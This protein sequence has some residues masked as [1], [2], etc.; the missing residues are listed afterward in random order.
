M[1]TC[2][3]GFKPNSDQIEEIKVCLIDEEKNYKEDFFCNWASVQQSFSDNKIAVLIQNKNAIGFISW[4]E[5]EKVARIQIAE[6]RPGYRKKGFGKYLAEKLFENL[7][8]RG[9][10][11]LDLHC[12]PASSEKVWKKLGFKRF[13]GARDFERE[14]S[15]NGRYLYKVLVPH[16]RPAK[17]LTA[18]ESIEI[19]YAEPH[20]ARTEPAQLRWHPKFEKGTRN[21]VKPIIAS[22]KRDWQISWNK[23]E[24][25]LK[26]DKIKYFS[27]NKID[28]GN[29]III[30]S[31][32]YK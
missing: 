30:N 25:I 13:P 16:L 9:F 23:Q 2:K 5:W 31:L 22:A 3:V 17:S 29:F 12:Q 6:I 32:I 21:L 19:W 11:V 15:P 28:F 26:I 10:A 20:L 4:F 1:K 7:L 14:N 24:E 27:K 8:K 18:K